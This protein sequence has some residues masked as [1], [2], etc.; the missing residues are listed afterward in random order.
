M[1]R[2][3]KTIG[4]KFIYYPSLS[5]N[6][7]YTQQ[8]VNMMANGHVFTAG[9]QSAYTIAGAYEHIHVRFDSFNVKQKAGS[10]MIGFTLTG[11]LIPSETSII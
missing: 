2:L 7:K 10:P 5:A 1:S 8:L 9:E 11:V 3:V 4:Y 6:D